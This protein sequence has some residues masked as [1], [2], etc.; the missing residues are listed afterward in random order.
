M[1]HVELGL[2]V[3]LREEEQQL[4]GAGQGRLHGELGGLSQI[5]DQCTWPSARCIRLV[6]GW[7]RP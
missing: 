5:T 2:W 1:G 4:L 7:G 6:R 3:V